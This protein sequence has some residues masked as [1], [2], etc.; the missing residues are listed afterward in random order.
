MAYRTIGAVLTTVV[1]FASLPLALL[2][3]ER[4]FGLGAALTVPTC[5]IA[6]WFA[7]YSRRPAQRIGWFVFA[8]INVLLLPLCPWWQRV[9]EV[10]TVWLQDI[11]RGSQPTILYS[12]TETVSIL[13]AVSYTHLTLPTILLV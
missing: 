10:I 1:V 11:I 4:G 7:M 12:I 2:A 8:S 9:I 3:M 6:F 5:C 13:A